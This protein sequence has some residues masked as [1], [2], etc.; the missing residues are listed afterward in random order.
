MPRTLI[1]RHVHVAE[2]DEQARAEAQPE[3]LKGFFGNDA[4]MKAI[5]ATRIGFGGDPRMTGGERTPDIE[6]RG[7]VFGELAKSYDFWIESGL[8]LV[9]SPE[10]VIRRLRDQQQRLGYDV[11]LAQHQ[12]ADMPRPQVLKSLELF[13]RE[14]VPACQSR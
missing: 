6:E 2:T 4:A 3:L 5:A 13:G 14:V 7:R 11:F 1:A 9:G 12:L 10:T 8:A